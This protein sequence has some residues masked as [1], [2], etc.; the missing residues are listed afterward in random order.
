MRQ[1]E[2][3]QWMMGEQ[4][5]YLG[6]WDYYTENAVDSRLSC[7]LRLE[8]YFKIDLDSKV[9]NFE[10]A[11]QF[12]TDIRNAKIEDLAHTPLSNAFRHYY[13]FAT[14]ETIEKIF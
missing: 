3:K 13:K 11:K 2:F 7:L 6:K 8:S 12:L 14:G 10:T 1:K 5:Y 9:L 4:R